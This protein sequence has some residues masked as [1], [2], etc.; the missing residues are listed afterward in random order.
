MQ[1]RRNFIRRENNITRAVEAVKRG[2]SVRNAADRFKVPKSTL[3][4]RLTTPVRQWPGR[5]TAFIQEE[6]CI[7]D[8]VLHYA[9]TGVPLTQRHLCEAISVVL[10]NLTPA[11]RL[12]LPF[13]RDKPSAGYLRTFRRRHGKVIRFGKPLRQEP[14]RFRGVNSE[15][16]TT[17]F[18]TIEKL[19]AEHNIDSS[20]LFNLVK[21]GVSPGKDADVQLACRRL[22]N[23]SGRQDFIIA[24]FTYENRITMMPII[25]A[26]SASSDDDCAP[27][28]FV[29]K[30]KR[31][32]YKEVLQNGNVLPET[33]LSRLPRSSVSAT[34]EE[35][36]GG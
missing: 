4:Y 27:P 31:V 6:K 32:P 34:R 9:T 28:L 22:T 30:G 17:H 1:S 19:I 15:S 23:K 25:N 7:V 2:T 18:A 13:K 16:L 29:M 24:D 20:G 21:V 33:P 8:F 5:K 36:R 26:E 10:G 3:H 12:T 35:K 11:R 14:K